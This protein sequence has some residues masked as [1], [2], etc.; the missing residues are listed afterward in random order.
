MSI[1]RLF[2]SILVFIKQ[3]W[4][5]VSAHD[6]ASFLF[7]LLIAVYLVSKNHLFF[8]FFI[9]LSYFIL[10]SIK[11]FTAYIVFFEHDDYQDEIRSMQNIVR[12][13][14]MDPVNL[15]LTLRGGDFTSEDYESLLELDQNISINKGLSENMKILF[16]VTKADESVLK[17]QKVCS[18]CLENLD[19]GNE[20]R[21]L[22]CSHFFHTECIDKWFELSTKCPVCNKNFK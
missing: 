9:L 16:P 15:R 1:T 4:R 21:S 19:L 20:L 2:K 6:I 12:I 3:N 22:P 8:S 17:M 11:M 13:F 7:V 10:L 5:Q 14:G 18:V